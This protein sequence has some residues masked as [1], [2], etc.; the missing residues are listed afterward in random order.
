MNI[1]Y[2]YHGAGNDFIIIDNRDKSFDIKNKENIRLFCDRHF[3][4]G[5]DGIILL[6]KQKT[7]DFKMVYINSDGSIGSMC[8]NGGRCIVDFAYNVLKIIKNPQNINFIAVDGEHKAEIL[9]DGQVKLKMQDIKNISTRNDLPFIICGTTPHNI[10]F[11][12]N[13]KEFPVFET[14]RKIRNSDS[15]PNGINTNFVEIKDDIV[16]VR[17]YEWGVEDETLACGTGAVSV[18]IACSRLNKIKSNIC[19]IKMPGGILIVEFEKE[20]NS[21]KNI[22]LTGPAVCVF[23]GEIK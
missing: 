17:T 9:E 11:V 3:G 8:G 13:L 19:H 22:Y 6:E 20:N 2:K 23:K 12:E 15:N 7:Y 5:A 1:F 10:M 21:Y 18:A 4:I 14:G 16:N